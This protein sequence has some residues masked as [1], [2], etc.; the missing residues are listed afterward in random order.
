[1]NEVILARTGVRDEDLLLLKELPYLRMLSLAHTRITPSGLQYLRGLRQLRTLN[2]YKTADFKS[3]DALR[4][5]MPW[6]TITD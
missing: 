1:M 2:L 5:A 6:C 3:V 4:E